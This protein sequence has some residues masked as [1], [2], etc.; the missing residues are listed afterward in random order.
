M[1]W[2]GARWHLATGLTLLLPAIALTLF[3]A[4]DGALWADR[5]ITVWVQEHMPRWLEPATATTN[6]IGRFERMAVLAVLV[7]AVLSLLGRPAEGV[8]VVASLSAWL[9]N[10]ILKQLAERPR[11][12]AELAS[13]GA[14]GFSFPSGH[15]MGITVVLAILAYVLTRNAALRVKAVAGLLV[16]AGAIV[17]GLGRVES[18]VHWPSDVLG[19]WLWAALWSLLL[20]AAGRTFIEGQRTL[21]T[22]NRDGA[23]PDA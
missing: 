9:A 2:Y 8:L 22:G 13:A 12:P 18:G 11:P 10:S 23:A 17:A 7:A 21:S 5:S 3:A 6:F 1:N 4:G 20:M 16:V 19:G 15:V 14:T